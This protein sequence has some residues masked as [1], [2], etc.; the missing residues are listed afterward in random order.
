MEAQR[1]PADYDGVLVCGPAVHRTRSVAAWT[2]VARA[3]AA[4]PGSDIP[5]AKLAMIHGA[6]TAACDALDGLQD[7]LI[8]EPMKCRFD[9]ASLLCHGAES[10]GCL[11]PAQVT[12]L[13]K[14]YG[15]PLNS[16]GEAIAA[17]FLPGAETDPAS[18]IS[19]RNCKASALHRASIFLDGMFDVRFKVDTFDFDR[20]LA[21]LERTEDAKLT[22][23]TSPNLKAFKDRGG[24][25]II[26]HGWNDGAD[27][28][29]LSVKYFDS[30][31]S[32]M[33]RNTV[34]RFFRLYMV[35]GV[36]HNASRGPGPTA[37]PGPMQR[38]LEAWV[39]NDAPPEAIVAS[40]YNVDGDPSSGVVRTRPWCPYPQI[41]GY[42]GEGNI[43]D[44]ANFVCRTP[45]E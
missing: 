32:T 16:K 10:D 28:A 44:A 22:N 27:P 38:A 45:E 11:T 34:D 18:A 41:A 30:V 21:A 42:R 35:P 37:F 29:L 17:G 20:D 14:S 3:V 33:G 1:Y 36:Y 4:E 6:V 25:L 5:P 12:V 39:E 7:G 8:S 26:V 9:P 43:D 19:C 23:T 24:K 2:W 15:G 40:T 13:K 31:V